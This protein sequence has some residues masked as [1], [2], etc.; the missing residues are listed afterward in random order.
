MTNSKAVAASIVGP[1]VIN[2]RERRRFPPLLTVAAVD[3]IFISTI[4]SSSDYWFD[5]CVGFEID[6]RS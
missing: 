6:Y 1:G 3:V 4:S 2:D 5:D